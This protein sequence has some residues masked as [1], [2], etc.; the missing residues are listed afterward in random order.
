V[1]I[2]D[3]VSWSNFTP[4]YIQSYL[5]SYQVL[6]DASN[7]HKLLKKSQK[8]WKIST[9]LAIATIAT[10]NFA[11]CRTKVVSS[12]FLHLLRLKFSL[13]KMLQPNG[14][15]WNIGRTFSYCSACGKRFPWAPPPRAPGWVAHRL[16]LG[17]SAWTAI[18]MDGCECD[19]VTVCNHRGTEHWWCRLE[20]AA[21]EENDILKSLERDVWGCCSFHIHLCV[22]SEVKRNEKRTIKRCNPFNNLDRKCEWKKR[23]C[24]WLQDKCA[25]YIYFNV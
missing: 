16:T 3:Q 17:R 6:S 20:I 19:A 23:F 4:M 2:F 9:F 7:K 12:K 24:H 5:F 21:M 1:V 13:T 18:S 10:Q 22:I 14:Y 8:F 11:G 25:V 15:G